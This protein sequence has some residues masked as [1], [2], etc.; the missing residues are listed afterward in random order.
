VYAERLEY[1]SRLLGDDPASDADGRGAAASAVCE[2]NEQVV[3]EAL[4]AERQM[5]VR[6]RDDGVIGDEVLRKV[7]QD[8]DLEESK[9]EEDGESP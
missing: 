3:R 5:L 2:T 9:L 1:Y 8:L 6:L 7:Q 4:A